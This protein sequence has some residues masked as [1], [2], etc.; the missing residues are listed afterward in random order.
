MAVYIPLNEVKQEWMGP[1][2]HGVDQLRVMGL[3]SH[4]YQDAFG[5]SFLPHGFLGV[6]Y[7]QVH[8]VTWGSVLKAKHAQAPPT[9][10]LPYPLTP[11]NK[12]G[13]FIARPLCRGPKVNYVTLT[14]T[15]PDGHLLDSSQELLHWMV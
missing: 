4:I 6:S 15:N 7:S 1:R 2:G 13:R 5:M 11:M 3:H 12:W 14:L 10:M 9:V 8:H